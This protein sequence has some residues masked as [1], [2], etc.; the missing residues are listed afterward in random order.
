MG[1]WEVIL[2]LGAEVGSVI[3]YGLETEGGWLFPEVWA[4]GLQS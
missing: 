4:I 3:L 2:E 1:D